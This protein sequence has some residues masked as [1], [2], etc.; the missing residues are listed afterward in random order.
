LS[1]KHDIV[2]LALAG[3]EPQTQADKSRPA[4]ADVYAGRQ[5]Q[6]SCLWQARNRRRRQSC[7]G[8]Q[9]HTLLKKPEAV[10]LAL[11][12]R[13]LQA[14]AVISKPAGADVAQEAMG[15]QVSSSIS[16]KGRRRHI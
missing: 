11:A 3:I 4:A 13:E 10:K 12:A 9:G 2:K 15:S 8:R 16:G 7:V 1:R 14:Q 5:T 6:S